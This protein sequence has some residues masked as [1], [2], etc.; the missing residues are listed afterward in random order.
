MSIQSRLTLALP[1]LLSVNLL[2]CPLV[3]GQDKNKA[4]DTPQTPEADMHYLFEGRDFYKK[5]DLNSAM[6][7]FK[8]L[9]RIRPNN[10][11]V[12]FWIG[13][14]YDETN[15]TKSAMDEYATC[16]KLAAS[17]N[18]DAP[19]L[20]INLGNS[21][22]RENYNKEA[23]FDFRRAIE[24]DKRYTLAN[25]GLAKSLLATGDYDSALT[26][27]DLY[28]RAGGNDINLYLIKGLALACKG[29]S[30]EASTQL[31]MFLQGARAKDNAT[32]G[33]NTTAAAMQLAIATLRE[34]ELA[35]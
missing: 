6:Q 30:Q 13:L 28:Q 33:G 29:S 25:L 24:I 21:L 20:R 8:E 32:T 2:L 16:L 10:L 19:E 18:M 11:A 23:L 3:Y 1:L 12:H 22:A 17:V 31:K 7:S 35:P 4:F 5:G 26:A 27:A 34:I 9:A 15:N 14:I